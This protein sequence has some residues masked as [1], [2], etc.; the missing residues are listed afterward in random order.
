MQPEIVEEAEAEL[1]TA[2]TRYER[3][4]TGLGRDFLF[5]YLAAVERIARSPRTGVLV[6]DADGFE[7]RRFPLH[8]FPYKLFIVVRDDVMSGARSLPSPITSSDPATGASDCL[9]ETLRAGE[10]PRAANG[11]P[12]SANRRAR[13]G[14]EARDAMQSV[15]RARFESSGAGR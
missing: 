10:L 12:R 11:R 2:A 3:E 1:Q 4:R 15:C 13:L 9:A 7:V 6:P 14:V 8:R 5:E